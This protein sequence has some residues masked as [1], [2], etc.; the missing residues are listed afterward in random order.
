MNEIEIYKGADGETQIEVKFEGETVWLNQ[1]QITQ[2]F[3]RERSVITKHIRNIFADGELEKNA[4]CAF[5]AHTA[6]DGKTYDVEYYNLDVVIS[7]GYRVKSKNGVLFRRWA[8]LRLKEYLVRG[9]SINQKRLD[10][11]Q[12]VVDVIQLTSNAKQLN[13]EEATGL[14]NILN[15]YARSFV[16]L[17][18][19]DNRT[20]N[21]YSVNEGITY[22]IT[23]HEASKAIYELRKELISLGEAS[24]LFGKMKD[25]SFGGTLK[26]ITQTFDGNYLY[27]SVEEQAAN[28]LYLVIK[29]HFFV[30]GN[31]RI[32][33]FLFVW[34]LEK[35]RHQFKKSGELKINDNALIALT[36]LVAQSN[37]SD[38]DIMVKLIVNLI[39]NS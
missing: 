8:T 34:F 9:Y 30:D 18:Q 13:I 23:Y 7:I 33:A 39:D 11:L 28:L 19:F 14:L 15:Q 16:L 1:M 25:D 38:K 5:F 37:P 12:K 4:V 20:L 27:P 32:G 26:A 21:T 31:K 10:Q 29:N 3:D 35:N 22:E 2:L 6:D 24:E 17:S 36:L